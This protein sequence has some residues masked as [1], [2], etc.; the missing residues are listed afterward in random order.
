MPASAKYLHIPN[1]IKFD[2]ITSFIVEIV[3]MQYR[4]L[5]S[6]EVVSNLG[7]SD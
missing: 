7:A 4:L 6:I 3:A 5:V 1:N 2:I